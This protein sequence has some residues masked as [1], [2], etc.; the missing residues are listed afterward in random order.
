MDEPEIQL[1]R[2]SRD[3][4]LA[5]FDCGDHDLNE[6]IVDDALTYQKQ[7]LANTTLLLVDGEIRTYFALAS[8]AIRLNPNE[9]NAYGIATPL[10]N[11]PALKIARL[12]THAKYRGQGFGTMA[13]QFCVGLARHLNDEHRHDGIG[14]R[15]ITVDAYRSALDWYLARGFIEN[16]TANN[17]KRDNV[18][19]RLDALPYED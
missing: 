4:D 14:C 3:Y 2:L 5:S 18:S 10:N 8:D 1:V 13:L 17:K 6:F 19:L 15:F 9:K 16:E 11:F 7:F 12:A